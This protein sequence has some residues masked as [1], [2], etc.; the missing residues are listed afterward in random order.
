M[1]SRRVICIVSALTMFA[2]LL[3]SYLNIASNE[4]FY[5]LGTQYSTTLVTNSVDP[6]VARKI[7]QEA[8]EASHNAVYLM[9][10]DPSNPQQNIVIYNITNAPETR[11]KTSDLHL[12]IPTRH[13]VLKSNADLSSL[14]LSGEYYFPN[15]QSCSLFSQ[16][17]KKS[18]ITTLNMCAENTEHR[19][20]ITAS[21][22]MN[23]VIVVLALSLLSTALAWA[24]EGSLAKSQQIRLMNG[25]PV[26]LICL[27]DTVSFTVPYCA[28]ALVC[29]AFT[30]IAIRV[31]TQAD[32]SFWLVATQALGTMTLLSVFL[33]LFTGIASLLLHPR[34]M[35]LA[36]RDNNE[37]LAQ[38]GSSAFSLVCF[39]LILVSLPATV[40]SVRF[41]SQEYANAARWASVKNAVSVQ[42]TQSGLSDEYAPSFVSLYHDLAQQKQ[43]AI[44]ESIATMVLPSRYVQRTQEKTHVTIPDGYSDI[45]ITNRTFL[46]TMKLPESNLI[47]LSSHNASKTVQ[48]AIFAQLEQYNRVW[49]KKNSNLHLEKKVY[50]WKGSP[51]FP[52]LGGVNATDPQQ[53]TSSSHPLL[54]VLDTADEFEL[55]SG[56]IPA[57]ISQGTLFFTD[58]VSL[59]AALVRYQLQ[60]AVSTTLPVAQSALLE[61]QRMSQEIITGIVAIII[62]ALTLLL[63]VVQAT[64]IWAQQRRNSIFLRMTSGE[65]RVRILLPHVCLHALVLS[66]IALGFSFTWQWHNA[67]SSPLIMLSIIVLSYVLVDV[68]THS[69]Q[70]DQVVKRT[71]TR[72]E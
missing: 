51:S 8:A 41:S 56:F 72:Q 10:T 70:C 3:I 25:T 71:I 68:C 12:L 57:G 59:N 64:W 34:V 2:I 31:T 52:V 29:Y 65:T 61:A 40:A 16:K 22:G 23:S 30:L 39:I 49:G 55:G 13:A 1:G 54:V 67:F 66:L 50:E 36:H 45:V 24:C 15:R 37:H 44:S 5:P 35:Q 48:S 28:T 19:W 32:S 18:G 60:P 4:M 9:K 63:N 53:I 7:I 62:A 42:T 47:P 26:P 11:G 43:T 38:Y 6:P 69:Y 17:I 21:N 14:S 20:L 58:K 27:Q 46:S 33:F